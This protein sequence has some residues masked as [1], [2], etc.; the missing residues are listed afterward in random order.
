LPLDLTDKDQL[1]DA[2]G[3]ISD[4]IA[5]NTRHR[6][7][8]MV[9]AIDA[10]ASLREVGE[11]AGMNHERVRYTVKQMR[12]RGEAAPTRAQAEALKRAGNAKVR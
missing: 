12:E 4:R 6:E 7:Q 1:L 11:S 8:L 9:L 10:G 2:I 5:E 3:L